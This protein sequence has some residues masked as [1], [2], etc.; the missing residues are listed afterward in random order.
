VVSRSRAEF[1]VRVGP[2]A[3]FSHHDD[4]DEIIPQAGP[5]FHLISLSSFI[6]MLNSSNLSTSADSSGLLDCK[7][8]DEIYSCSE[9]D[10]SQDSRFWPSQTYSPPILCTNNIVK[11]NIL[12]PVSRIDPSKQPIAFMLDHVFSPEECK[13][14][15][16]LT[17]S[18]AQGYNAALI[19]VGLGQQK[20]MQDVRNNDR[21]MVDDPQFSALLFHRIKTSIPEEM[22]R[23][24]SVSCNER[25][26]FLRYKPGQQFKA[27]YDGCF[28]RPDGV[29]RSYITVQL[30]LNDGFVGGETTFLDV[31]GRNEFNVVPKEGS[32]LIFEHHL[33]HQ[34][35]QL[36]EGT[37]YCLRTD[38]MYRPLSADQTIPA[39]SQMK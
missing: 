2:A 37:K 30:Y 5:R 11:R 32:V 10:L 17:E 12:F 38:I 13:K 8:F 31:N 25:L 27:H 9:P 4:D 35:S 18:S 33:L 26:R 24:V 7:S 19:N 16:K 36:I 29:E 34:G 22:N 20:L 3:A 1:S 21:C 15:I 39:Q 28:V 23:C 14:L 6:T